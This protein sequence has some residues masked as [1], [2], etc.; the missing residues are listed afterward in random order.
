MKTLYVWATASGYCDVAEILPG[1]AMLLYCV[2]AGDTLS[3]IAE[4]FGVGADHW[5]KMLVNG[6]T[7]AERDREMGPPSL[8]RPGDMVTIDPRDCFRAPLFIS[9]QDRR[10][11]VDRRTSNYVAAIVRDVFTTPTRCDPRRFNPVV[12]NGGRR[13]G[14]N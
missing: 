1:R 14:K 12:D 10:L 7:H 8:I 5:R 11:R 9:M 3:A 13:R 2:Q 6:K 4:R